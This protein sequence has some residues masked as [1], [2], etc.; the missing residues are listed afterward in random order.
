MRELRKL[1]SMFSEMQ[2][3]CNDGMRNN[4][5]SVG[6]DFAYFDRRGGG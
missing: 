3:D 1:N 4:N 2:E 6:V 5:T